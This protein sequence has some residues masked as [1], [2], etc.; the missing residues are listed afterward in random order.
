MFKVLCILACGVLVGIIASRASTKRIPDCGGL[1]SIVVW[2]MLWAF[3]ASIGE[4]NEIMESLPTVGA[5]GATLGLLSLCGSAVACMILQRLT[6]KKRPKVTTPGNKGL[7]GELKAMRG[8]LITVGIFVAGM[9]M[10][11]GDVVPAFIDATAISEWLLYVLIALVGFGLGSNPRPELMKHG[12][13]VWILLVA[14][15]SII[16]TIAAGAFAGLLPWGYGTEDSIA[17]V[18]GMGYYSLS[19]LMI[20]QLKAD[21]IGSAGALELGAV[22]LLCNLVRE[23]AT[24]LFAPAIGRWMGS[25]AL[26]GAAGVTSLD[27]TLPSIRNGCGE[28]AV[29]VALINGIS[30]E[31]ACPLLITAACAL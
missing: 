28:S 19:S 21:I 20:I 24:L 22:A 14:P 16:G 3:G 18:S 26:T 13:N 1:L 11:R 7:K 15:V 4:N 12:T 10:G 25:Y 6:G 5:R 30:L 27:V 9:G 17:A 23:L 31:I 2:L 8:S 29:A